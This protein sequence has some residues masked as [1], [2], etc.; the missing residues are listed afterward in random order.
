MVLVDEEIRSRSLNKKCGMITPFHEEQL[1]GA[2]YDVSM[3]GEITI[4]RNTGR[5]IDPSLE[6]DISSV[7]NSLSASD[8]GFLLSPGQYVLVGLREKL[9]IPEDIIAHIRPRTRYTR[10]GI[11]VAGQHCN[12]TYTGILQI[13]LFNAS[14]NIFVLKKG[15]IIAQLIFEQL[16][17]VPKKLYK[18]K[19]NAAYHNESEFRGAKFGETTWSDEG[20]K[21]YKDVMESLK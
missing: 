5:V 1:Q 15:L 14:G 11:I 16:S 9:N 3:S 8:S 4:L 19:D 10:S 12:P 18:D 13:G 20:K 17:S 7:Y 6:K 2:S 21:L